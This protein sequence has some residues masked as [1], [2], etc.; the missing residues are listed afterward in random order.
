MRIDSTTLKG[1]GFPSQS[2]LHLS[3]SEIFGFAVLIAL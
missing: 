2:N 1:L 3:H